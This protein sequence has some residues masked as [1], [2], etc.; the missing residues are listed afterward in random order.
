MMKRIS[1]ATAKYAVV[2]FFIV[3]FMRNLEYNII[4]AN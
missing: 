2:C 4:I 3:E 1:Q